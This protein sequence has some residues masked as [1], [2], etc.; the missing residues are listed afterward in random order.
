MDS[1]SLPEK[2]RRVTVFTLDQAV[3]AFILSGSSVG[4]IELTFAV[5]MLFEGIIIQFI[6][7]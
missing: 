5:L 2:V 1:G 6:D 4:R 3:Y 7:L